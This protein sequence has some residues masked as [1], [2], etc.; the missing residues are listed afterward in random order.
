[1]WV[2]LQI[3]FVHDTA[4]LDPVPHPRRR[5]DIGSL[6]LRA[7][8]SSTAEDGALDAGSWYSYQ[9]DH[10]HSATQ[11]QEHRQPACYLPEGSLED[12]FLGKMEGSGRR[13]WMSPGE[14]GQSRTLAN[15]TVR[16]S[17]P[18]TQGC[19]LLLST[20]LSKMSPQAL[21]EITNIKESKAKKE[22][23]GTWEL[24]GSL[25]GRRNNHHGND[26]VL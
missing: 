17:W 2:G 5:L 13:T 23:R 24:T 14:S 6:K 10:C 19:H 25:G 20:R 11:L 1:M 26:K 8:G 12:S 16:G 7:L 9:W 21:R 4:L 22:L 15:P 18:H 3:A